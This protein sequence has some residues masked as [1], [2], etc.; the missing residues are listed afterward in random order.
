MAL[1]QRGFDM[2]KFAIA[3]ITLSCIGAPV[4]AISAQESRDDRDLQWLY[5]ERHGDG[6]E[7]PTAIFLSWNYGSVIFRASCEDFKGSIKLQYFPE[8]EIGK[9]GPDGKLLDESFPPIMIKRGEETI[10]SQAWVED[11]IVESRFMTD[12][13]LSIIL[14]ATEGELEIIADNAMGDP[15]YV[16]R[17]EPLLQLAKACR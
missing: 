8:P 11:G 14:E 1:A 5:R 13:R 7:T 4:S 16:G 12:D 3:L 10:F 2:K 15:W 6:T 9:R 17:A